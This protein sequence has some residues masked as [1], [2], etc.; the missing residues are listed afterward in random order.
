MCAGVFW[1]RK[2]KRSYYDH[3]NCDFVHSLFFARTV[4]VT[5]N[6]LAIYV[7]C[8]VITFP[9]F[10]VSTSR[11]EWVSEWVKDTHTNIDITFLNETKR[12][13]EKKITLT[14]YTA[15]CVLRVYDLIAFFAIF[16]WYLRIRI[17]VEWTKHTHIRASVMLYKNTHTHI[18]WVS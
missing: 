11:K 16:Q 4:S 6:I 3:N 10:M 5:E 18:I 2:A 7:V 12:K 1:Y 15:G 17:S 9:L 14:K 13:K 8:L